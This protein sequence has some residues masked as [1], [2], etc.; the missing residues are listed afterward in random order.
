MYYSLILEI[1]NDYFTYF[2]SDTQIF[3]KYL[4]KVW[5]ISSHLKMFYLF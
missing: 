2:I 5:A 1:F 3:L 4:D